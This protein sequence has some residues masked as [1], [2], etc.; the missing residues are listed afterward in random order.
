MVVLSKKL[1]RRIGKRAVLRARPS[2]HRLLG[3]ATLMDQ[4]A[5]LNQHFD[6]VE[7]VIESKRDEYRNSSAGGAEAAYEVLATVRTE[8]TELRQSLL[9]ATTLVERAKAL[10]VSVAQVAELE[11]SLSNMQA[12]LVALSASSTRRT[13]KNYAD[14][15]DSVAHLMPS[16]MY[17]RFRD[18]V[19]DQEADRSEWYEDILPAVKQA[20]DLGFR[21]LELDPLSTTWLEYLRDCGVPALGVGRHAAALQGLEHG[22][23]LNLIDADM[24]THV[25]QSESASVSSVVAFELLERISPDEVMALLGQLHR[26]VAPGGAVVLVSQ[27]PLNVVVGA[28]SMWIDPMVHRPVHPA[29]LGFALKETG[30]RE[31]EMRFSNPLSKRLDTY[32]DDRT[33]VD[34]L[35]RS[36]CLGPQTFIAI[37]KRP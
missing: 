15:P 26:V 18:E 35:L 6:E 4:M 13:S 7:D 22:V 8:L 24:L 33:D 5:A 12:E 1:V 30:F 29:F 17:L 2:I 11:K 16:A 34:P 25:S 10:H 27:N 9:E 28:S 31:V 32:A 14:A 21:S 37:A 19:L 23:D 20:S 36:L 3:T